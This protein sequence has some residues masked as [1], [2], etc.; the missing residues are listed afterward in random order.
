[1]SRLQHVDLKIVLVATERDSRREVQSRLE[2]RD[3]EPGRRNDILAV[4]RIEKGGVVRAQRI[5]DCR[6]CRERRQREGRRKRQR[7]SQYWIAK[8]KFHSSPLRPRQ[9]A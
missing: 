2:N 5:R 8:R 7:G 4:S 6:Y 9:S 1:M 3:R